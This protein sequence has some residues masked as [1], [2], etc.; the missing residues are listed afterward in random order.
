[1]YFP[2]LQNSAIEKCIKHV[3]F[4]MHQKILFRG[5]NAK[6]NTL[7]RLKGL[8]IDFIHGE[9]GNDFIYYCAVC[10]LFAS[11][12]TAFYFIYRCL[13]S[14]RF[15][16]ISFSILHFAHI[17]F[18]TSFSCINWRLRR[19]KLKLKQKQ[20]P[21][22]SLKSSSRQKKLNLFTHPIFKHSV[23]YKV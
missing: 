21:Y 3:H 18:F 9:V 5:E 12:T 6:K 11:N 1:M 4:S 17:F 16:K 19:N 7:H 15:K 14:R 23:R 20:K 22:L 2:C 10:M 13:I 8:K